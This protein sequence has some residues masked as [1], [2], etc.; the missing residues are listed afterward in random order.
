MTLKSRVQGSNRSL[1]AKIPALRLISQLGGSNTRLMVLILTLRDKFLSRGGGDV[2]YIF[3]FKGRT[4]FLKVCWLIAT[5]VV[6]VVVVV[7]FCVRREKKNNGRLK[8]KVKQRQLLK[9]AF[10]FVNVENVA[11]V[12]RGSRHRSTMH[13]KH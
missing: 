7:V 3:H 2:K 12:K 8:N 5:V 1:E 11:C 9:N 4:C 10:H 13:Q 6:V